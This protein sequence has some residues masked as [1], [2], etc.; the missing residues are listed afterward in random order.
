MSQ[1][2]ERQMSADWGASEEVKIW[3]TLRLDPML[4]GIIAAIACF[5]LVVLYSA[6]DQNEAL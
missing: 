3:R 2:Y 1:E 5:G 4:L 6:A